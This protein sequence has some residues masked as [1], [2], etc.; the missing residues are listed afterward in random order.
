MSNG[1]EKRMKKGRKNDIFQLAG[2]LLLLV[3]LSTI[4]KPCVSE[5]VML[6]THSVNV[7]RLL[8]VAVAASA[9]FSFLQ[10]EG[11]KR[12][13]NLLRILLLAEAVVVPAGLIGGCKVAT[14]PCLTRSFPA[15]YVVS[16]LLIAGNLCAVIEEWIK[17]KE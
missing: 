9:V 16:G 12:Y 15:V 11:G 10:K 14:M 7:V 13:W 17:G 5:K 4:A 3:V 2:S 8:L 1:S 6:C